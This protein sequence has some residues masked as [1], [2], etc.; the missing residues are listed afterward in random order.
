MSVLRVRER[1]DE[2]GGRRV[3]SLETGRGGETVV[4]LPGLGAVGYM[5][6]TLAGCASWARSF[7]LDVPGFG[8]RPPRPCPAEVP[9]AADLVGEWLETVP[10]GPVVLAGHSSGAQIALRAA[11]AHPAR[12]RA[13]VLLGL[14]FPPRQRTLRRAAL[15]FLR[16]VVRESPSV[17]PATV[18]YFLRGGPAAVLRCIRT[19]QADTPEYLIGKIACPVLVVR[20]TRDGMCPRAWADG[21]AITAPLGRSVTVPGAHTFPFQNGGLTAALIAEAARTAGPHPPMRPSSWRPE[22]PAIV[23]P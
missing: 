16:T 7:L 22:S 11:A 17:L 6:D 14:T 21:L 1:W 4:L 5:K 3:R 20:G 23:L 13:L 9:A 8:H 18:P 2:I 12:V 10:D 15:P 19:A